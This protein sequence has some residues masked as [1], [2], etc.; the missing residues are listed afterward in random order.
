MK[1]I[2]LPLAL[3]ITAALATSCTTIVQMQR[4]YPPEAV[5]PEDSSRFVFVNF[6][7]YQIPEFIKGNHEAAYATAVKGYTIGLSEIILK[8]PRAVFM[9]A[10]TLK[11]GFTVMSMQ[12]PEFTDTVKTICSQYGANLLVAL[13]SIRLWVE[14]EFYLAE[15]DEG[16][17]TMAKDFYLFSNTYMTLYTSEGEV[18]DRCAG[19]KSTYIKSKYTIFGMIG[20]PT[21]AGRRVNVSLLTGEA[22]RDCLGKYYPFTERYLEKLYAGGPLTSINKSIMAGKPEEA[23]EPLRQLVVS[24]NPALARKASHNLE[25]VSQ[26]ISNR[27]AT[28]EV[29]HEYRR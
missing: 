3:I 26:M 10:D 8:D 2:S 18:I 19:E 5:L 24:N 23:L 4:T 11:K 9:V 17:S 27:Q 12:Y 15:N 14:S 13:D 21:L 20:G 29:W 28:E 7:D 6:Y 16:G 25:V 1:R 22:A